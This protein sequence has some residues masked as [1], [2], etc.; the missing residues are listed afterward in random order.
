MKHQ[1][2]MK[3]KIDVNPATKLESVIP[4]THKVLFAHCTNGLHVTP[5]TFEKTVRPLLM[6][7]GVSEIRI[8]QP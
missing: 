8:I 2:S 4:V 6:A 1:G 7:H 3:V 5:E